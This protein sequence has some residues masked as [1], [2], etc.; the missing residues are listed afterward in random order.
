MIGGFHGDVAKLIEKDMSH[1]TL[2]PT[3]DDHENGFYKNAISLAASSLSSS[4]APPLLSTVSNNEI[5]NLVE[6]WSGFENIYSRR[7]IKSVNNWFSQ[8]G[9][10]LKVK[11]ERKNNL[12]IK[13]ISETQNQ[14]I[15]KKFFG[16]IKSIPSKI[17]NRNMPDE[18][19]QDRT[20]ESVVLDEYLKTIDSLNGQMPD[21]VVVCVN[22]EEEVKYYKNIVRKM[23]RNMPPLE[24]SILNL[25][26]HPTAE[27]EHLS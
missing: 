20:R 11:R 12:I 10:P 23:K 18:I 1:I 19:Y 13:D 16:F 24:K 21:I 7:T 9:L 2:M 6:Y 26:I 17:L 25:S 8:K 5:N 4:L 15:F 14:N 22:D 27:Q 3:I